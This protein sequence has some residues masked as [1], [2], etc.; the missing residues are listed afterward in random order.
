MEIGQTFT[1]ERV[2]SQDDFNRF[3]RLSG[4]DNPIHVDPEFS[5]RTKFG[6][7]VAHGMLLYST[8]CAA[9]SATISHGFPGEG[10]VQLSQELMFPSPTFVDEKIEICLEVAAFLTSE[11]IEISTVV[12]RPNGELGCAGKTVILR[13]EVKVHFAEPVEA[14]IYA[15]EAQQHRGLKLGQRATRQRTFSAADVAD[16]LALTGEGNR[17]L[18][19]ATYARARGLEN[20]ILPGGLLGGMIS[21]LLGTEL[22]GR[23]TNWLK[24]RY[25]FLKPAYP[26]TSIT[27]SVEVVRLRLEKELVTLR[28]TCVDSTGD[29]VLE[30]EALVWVSDLE[31]GG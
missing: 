29:V 2:F 11:T 19:D 4:D 23:G 1:A 5:A 18:G 7:T 30:G 20:A 24:Q 25:A 17:F 28:A 8:I 16:F 31:I 27:A 9:I 3:A 13:P 10:F 6:K 15:S 14:P 12:A 21:D 26:D 22:P